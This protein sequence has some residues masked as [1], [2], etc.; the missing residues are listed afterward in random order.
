MGR[1]FLDLLRL[2]QWLRDIHKADD[3]DL[4]R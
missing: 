3:L 2:N 4:K 1:I